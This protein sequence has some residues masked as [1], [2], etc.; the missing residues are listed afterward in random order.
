MAMLEEDKWFFNQANE[1]SSLINNLSLSFSP[2]F[3]LCTHF[4]H[5]SHES[6]KKR[7]AKQLVKYF[8]QYRVNG[9]I[10][11]QKKEKE[12]KR[13]LS[14][15][16]SL[17]HT[18]VKRQQPSAVFAFYLRNLIDNQ[19]GREKRKKASERDVIE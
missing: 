13:L 2:A 11:K 18:G 8:L 10:K 19:A 14:L 17:T 16:F 15:S 4:R 9:Q 12:I 6:Q 1:A 3:A 5:D 7:I